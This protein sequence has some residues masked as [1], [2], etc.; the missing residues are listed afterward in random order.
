MKQTRREFVRTLFV[1]TQAVVASRFLSTGGLAA[2]S[3]PPLSAGDFNFLVFGDWGR[4]GEP[5]QS[6]VAAEMAKNAD[7]TKARF[8]ISA[9]DNFYSYGV[10]S[11]KDPQW[12][13]SF[14]K[15][16]HQP[17]LQIPWHVVLGNHDYNGNTDAQIEYGRGHSRWNM[18]ARYYSQTHRI[19]DATTA[20]FFYLD[21]SPMIASYRRSSS[22]KRAANLAGQDP[23]K[24]LAWFKDA[25]VASQ[26]AWKI[27]IAHHPI[28]SGGEHGD[29][30]ELI[31]DILP[32]LQEHKVQAWFNGH[33]HDLQH[34]MA[35][36][37]NLFCC[38]AGS[39]VRPT[40]K[41]VHTKFAKTCP[42]FTTVS[43]QP[44]RMLIRM[45]D[46]HGQLL[47]STTVTVRAG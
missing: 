39:L 25:L 2:E 15:V 5:N 37:V 19:N 43:L 18:P 22:G 24:Q 16:Y 14:E 42:G 17:A 34:L 45:T 40:K 23:K 9:G 4:N 27:V 21:T 38:G 20:D 46:N 12:Q 33:D 11:V 6:Q 35:G 1:A 3:A 31:R 36:D 44:D 13:T 30:A 47:Y 32:L 26:A 29:T 7:A 8:V 41:T 10:D 28:Y